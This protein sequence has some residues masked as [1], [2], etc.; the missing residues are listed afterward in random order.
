MIRIRNIPHL[1][2]APLEIPEQWAFS[3]D[4]L[5]GLAEADGIS[6]LFPV[7][8][9]VTSR[10]QRKMRPGISRFHLAAGL[11]ADLAADLAVRASTLLRKG[12]LAWH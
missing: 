12:C 11:A 7:L 8:F 5:I 9:R 4:W 10:V 1:I 3:E 2:A 6:G